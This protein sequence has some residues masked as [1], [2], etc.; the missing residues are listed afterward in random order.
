M[1]TAEQTEAIPFLHRSRFRVALNFFRSM[2]DVY[3]AF[4]LFCI[5]CGLS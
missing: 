3:E 2:A 5:F 4:C 1:N